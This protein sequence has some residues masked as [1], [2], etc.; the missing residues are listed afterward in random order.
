LVVTTSI[1][2][3][4][5]VEMISQRTQSHLRK[6]DDEEPV[7]LYQRIVGFPTRMS[8]SLLE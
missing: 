7:G 5:S 8:D 1:E 6:G 4:L 2:L 3:F